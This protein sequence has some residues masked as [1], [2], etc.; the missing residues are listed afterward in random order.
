LYASTKSDKKF[1]FFVANISH[2]PFSSKLKMSTINNTPL[3]YGFHPTLSE[4]CIHAVGPT[5]RLQISV[6]RWSKLSNLPSTFYIRGAH[7]SGCNWTDGDRQEQEAV[8]EQDSLTVSVP[9]SA[10]LITLEV[11]G[12]DRHLYLSSSDHGMRASL[13]VI[14]TNN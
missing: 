8:R 13:V 2:S 10:K 1:D 12:G 4:M 5:V 3:K 11:D 6:D 9:G 14:V 7:I